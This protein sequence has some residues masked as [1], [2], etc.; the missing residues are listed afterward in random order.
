MDSGT[1]FESALSDPTYELPD[2]TTLTV[3]EERFNVAECLFDPSV[4]AE[5]IPTKSEDFTEGFSR[6]IFETI[7]SCAE[8]IRDELYR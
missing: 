1:V 8:E 6:S 4:I 5:M 7:N 2:G 3:T